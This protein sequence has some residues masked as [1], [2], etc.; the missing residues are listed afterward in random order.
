MNFQL[1]DSLILIPSDV[2]VVA[3]AILDFSYYAQFQTHTTE[4]LGGLDHS[5]TVFHANKDVLK[6]LELR[7]HFNIP[8]LHQLSH[9]VQSIMLFGAADGFNTELPERLH[10]DFAKE[11]YRASNKRDY[12]EQMA[13]WLQRQEAVF[14]RGSYLNWLSQRS[15]SAN[16]T[17]NVDH[18]HSH[19]DSDSGVETEDLQPTPPNKNPTLPITQQPMAHILA[20]AP[21]HPR[22]SVQHLITAYGATSFLPAL[23]LFLRKHIPR[24]NIVPGPQDRFDVFRQVIIVAP[25]DLRAGDLPRRWRIRA[26]PEVHPG[27]GRKPGSP[28]RFDMALITLADTLEVSSGSDLRS[29]TL[30]GMLLIFGL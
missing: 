2:L 8:K 9:Y 19:Y 5:L 6:E 14:L 29:R 26:T 24:S 7:E 18:E 12:E 16:A 17:S 15:Q 23:Q 27:P 4:S 1:T 13:L 11:A 21:A 20:K 25:P 30:Q 28:A 22:Q 3:R 10:I